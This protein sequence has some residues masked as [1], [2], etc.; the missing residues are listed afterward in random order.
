MKAI[1]IKNVPKKWAP[2]SAWSW[3]LPWRC[4]RSIAPRSAFLGHIL[5]KQSCPRI[6]A[7]LLIYIKNLPGG[8]LW[9]CPAVRCTVQSA[10]CITIRQWF[11]SLIGSGFGQFDHKTFF[12]KYAGYNGSI[13]LLVKFWFSPVLVPDVEPLSGFDYNEK[14]SIEKL[15]C[16]FALHLTF[17]AQH[18]VKRWSRGCVMPCWTW[19]RVHAT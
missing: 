19:Q 12:V 10:Q 14:S 3:A 13:R 7:F 2:R 15:C 5:N 4:P 17:T 16:L 1:L 6:C 9:G 18:A 8:W 11:N